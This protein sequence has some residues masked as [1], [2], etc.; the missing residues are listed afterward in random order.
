MI[1]ELAFTMSMLFNELEYFDRGKCDLSSIVCP[2]ELTDREYIKQE[3]DNAGLDGDRAAAIVNR[4]SRFKADAISP[5]DDWGF[6]QWHRKY[7][8]KIIDECFGKDNQL[9]C[10]TR[11]AIAKV[12]R[13]GNWSAWTCAKNP[14]K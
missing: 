1:Y 10:E 6:Y 8:S 14:S 5:T 13:D 4:E 11:H 3:F 7:W 2:G 12:K 9:E